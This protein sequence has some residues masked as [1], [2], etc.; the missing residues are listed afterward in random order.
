MQLFIKYH[1]PSDLLSFDFEHQPT[2]DAST[3]LASVKEHVR[4]L[5]EV[6]EGRKS[7]EIK[8]AAQNSF[9]EAVASNRSQGGATFA[10]GTSATA[11]ASTGTSLAFGT[12]N[13]SN[14]GAPWGATATASA[15]G[16]ASVPSS[17]A[18][19]LGFGSTASASGT[20]TSVGGFNFHLPSSTS[21]AAKPTQPQFVPDFRLVG[22]SWAQLPQRIDKSL[23]E[24]DPESSL[25]P[26]IIRLAPVWQAK[27][28][29]SILVPQQTAVLAP[30][31]QKTER[32]CA[33]DL[34]DALSRS[35]ELPIESAEFHIIVATTHSF[36]HTLIAT[37]IEQNMNPIDKIE[38]SLCVVA[39]ILHE[40]PVA[41]L[42]AKEK[43]S[44][45]SHHSPNLISDSS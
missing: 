33:F 13:T 38:R 7:V 9:V 1:V 40:K 37:V 6:I 36:D 44:Q 2:A 5:L 14:S 28:Q 30:E 10:F 4:A 18:S 8:Q 19:G 27:T 45:V 31:Q 11:V 25:H 12:T 16:G 24:L 23:I 17:S 32:Q 29:A 3:R 15:F 20:P 22:S 26:T 42:I 21:S 35:G 41:D 34:L 43:M 39:S